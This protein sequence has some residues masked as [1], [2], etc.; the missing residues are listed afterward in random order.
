MPSAPGPPLPK[1]HEQDPDS[2]SVQ[3]RLPGARWTAGPWWAGRER[4]RRGR[5]TCSK[6]RLS[7][8]LLELSAGRDLDGELVE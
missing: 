3:N 7:D 4:M 8:P 1:V 5:P 6:L 2:N